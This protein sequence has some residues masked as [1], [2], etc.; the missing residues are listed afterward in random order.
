M[1]RK[2]LQWT[3]TDDEILADVTLGVIGKEVT[4]LA[5]ALLDAETAVRSLPLGLK[6][7]AKL[8]ASVT[9]HSAAREC[10]LADMR[11]G[12]LPLES[13]EARAIEHQRAAGSRMYTLLDEARA[14]GLA[15]QPLVNAIMALWG[16]L[17]GLSDEIRDEI[18]EHLAEELGEAG[19]RYVLGP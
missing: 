10:W 2:P 7:L 4:G 15:V 13:A 1:K 9:E 16:F 18:A 11:S 5:A 14:S 17:D 3:E 12:D 6:L 8:D 19:P